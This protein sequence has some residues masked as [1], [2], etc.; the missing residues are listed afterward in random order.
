VVDSGRVSMERT[1]ALAV[2]DCLSNFKVQVQVAKDLEG[3]DPGFERAISWPKRADCWP[4]A[5]ANSQGRAARC[6]SS[7][8]G[9]DCAGMVWLCARKGPE[10]AKN[11][12]KNRPALQAVH[13][14]S[15][16]EMSAPQAWQK[17]ASM[18]GMVSAR[19]GDHLRG[20]LFKLFARRLQG[21]VISRS[22]CSARACR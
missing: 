17:L 7:P 5:S 4:T 10:S 19:A 16:V 12:G 14:F 2:D 3:V 8:R 21:G 9:G 1:R 22:I 13:G 20:M 18:R 11:K 6:S 15:R